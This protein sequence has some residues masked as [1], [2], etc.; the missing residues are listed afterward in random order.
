MP[1]SREDH[2]DTSS[3][4][5]LVVILRRRNMREPEERIVGATWIRTAPC[6]KWERAFGPA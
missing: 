1:Y 2:L 6:R 3:E 5:T 4:R